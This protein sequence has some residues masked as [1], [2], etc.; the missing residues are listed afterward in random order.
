[1]ERGAIEKRFYSIRFQPPPS[2]LNANITS[3]MQISALSYSSLFHVIPTGEKERVPF[4]F[5]PAVVA[6]M[7]AM[8][9][10]RSTIEWESL[11]SPL[12]AFA[13]FVIILFFV[14]CVS[15]HPRGIIS[16]KIIN[17]PTP[18]SVLWGI[19]VFKMCAINKDDSLF[20]VE[21]ISVSNVLLECLFFCL[22]KESVFSLEFCV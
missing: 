14:F 10:E 18:L 9:V 17:F 4:S 2:P 12:C 22:T 15:N 21:I 1:M 13:P 20:A 6:I 7:C 16:R 8:K 5:Y 19:M 3:S 11:L